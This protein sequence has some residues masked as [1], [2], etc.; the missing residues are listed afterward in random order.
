M[1][2][3]TFVAAD[4]TG[5][6][7]GSDLSDALDHPHLLPSMGAPGEFVVEL[8]RLLVEAGIDPVH[9][10]GPAGTIATSAADDITVH[11]VDG[12]VRFVLLNDAARAVHDAFTVM[13]TR[14]GQRWRCLDG[15]SLEE[16]TP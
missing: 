12:T 15:G 7:A 10:D 16:F 1:S 13:A 14:R 5:T 9:V 6:P 3:H 4:P 8:G 11:Q 2:A